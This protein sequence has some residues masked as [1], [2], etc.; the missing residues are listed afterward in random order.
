[1]VATALY[2]RPN[3]NTNEFR[4]LIWTAEVFINLFHFLNPVKNEVATCKTS[5]IYSFGLPK[6]RSEPLQSKARWVANKSVSDF[7]IDHGVAVLICQ[8]NK[9]QLKAKLGAV[10]SKSIVKAKRLCCVARSQANVEKPV[11]LLPSL[12][13]RELVRSNTWETLIYRAIGPSLTRRTKY[14][15]GERIYYLWEG[16]KSS[17]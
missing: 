4:L 5:E 12:V 9:L 7:Y 1:M 2:N 6:M 11:S 10:D 16:Q 3:L 14:T 13:W 17:T 8:H 15:N